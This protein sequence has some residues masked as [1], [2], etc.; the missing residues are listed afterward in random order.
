MLKQIDEL[1]RIRKYLHTNPELSGQ[2][3]RTA[4]YI[5]N[6]LKKTKANE[7]LKISNTGVVA[8]FESEKA[9]ETTLF[10]ADIDALPIQ[11][12]NNFEY[13]SVIV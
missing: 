12:E 3:F 11:E 13:R 7:V 4:E 10:R 2:E 8:V 9:G 5:Y 6:N 1:I